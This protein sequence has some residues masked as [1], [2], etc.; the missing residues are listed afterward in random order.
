MSNTAFIPRKAVF[1][2]KQLESQWG[3]GQGLNWNYSWY[4]SYSRKSLGTSTWNFEHFEFPT[5]IQTKCKGRKIAGMEWEAQIFA[6]FFFET[7][8]QL[9][10]FKHP[11]HFDII[12]TSPE[13]RSWTSSAFYSFEAFSY[14]PIRSNSAEPFSVTCLGQAGLQGIQTVSLVDF[15]S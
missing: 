13:I 7:G 14:R 5:R 1:V 8:W 15:C 11:L 2:K 10:H 9:I 3:F 12:G 6:G 4:F